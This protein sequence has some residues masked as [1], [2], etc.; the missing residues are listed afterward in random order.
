[1]NR[2]RASQGLAVLALPVALLL[3]VP[4]SSGTKVL[5]WVD[6][7]GNTHYGDTSQAPADAVRLR[8]VVPPSDPSNFVQLDSQTVGDATDVYVRNE[9]AGPVQVRL[10]LQSKAELRLSE[11][12]R[13]DSLL[14]PT[15]KVRLG[16]VYTAGEMNLLLDIVPGDPNAQPRDVAYS[17]PIDENSHWSVGQTF[18]GGHSHSDAANRFAVDIIVPEGTP[19]LAARAG[20]VMQAE[21]S[22]DRAGSDR[23]KFAT[24]ANLVRILHDDG[25]IAVYAHL[26][27]DGVYVRLGERV[28]LG[29]QIG[30]SG[31]TGYSS[32]PH[33]HFAVQVNRGMSLQSIPFRMVGPSGY[34]RL[35]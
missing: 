18:N 14:P 7:N 15:T 30:A 17:L 9:L 25:S 33:L 10:H 24:R 28:G 22:F 12:F 26:Q 20:V 32:G 8:G 16:R 21:S 34:L 3:S 13:L 35:Q 23:A 27:E 2:L 31:N 1:M 29:Q 19:V 4:S 6:A 5:K 11:D